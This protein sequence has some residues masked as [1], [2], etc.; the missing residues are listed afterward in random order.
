MVGIV[1][2]PQVAQRPGAR[3]GGCRRPVADA[4]A[5]A[6][7]LRCGSLQVLREE[8][9]RCVARRASRRS[10]RYDRRVDV[11]IEGVARAFVHEDLRLRLLLRDAGRHRPAGCCCRRAPKWNISGARG[12]LVEERHA[13]RAVVADRRQAQAR[14]AHRKARLPPQQNPTAPTRRPSV[15][16]ISAAASMTSIARSK[17]SAE[18]QRRAPRCDAGLVVAQFDAV[19]DRIEQG[20]RE[21]HEPGS[22]EAARRRC[23]CARSRR[24]SP[25]SPPPRP[26]KG[27][28]APRAS[29]A[30]A[31]AGCRCRSSGHG[32]GPPWQWACGNRTPW[33]IALNP[34]RGSDDKRP[35]GPRAPL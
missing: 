17:P 1:H 28:A 30:P 25:G 8:I 11:A 18:T 31:R 14:V 21:R 4:G 5:S 15:C 10:A 34:K 29:P 20:R 23:G 22:G 12:R 33:E 9:E 13:A 32:R 19:L 24:R 35:Y 26:S 16:S 7:R 2:Q 3:P 6:S 27:P